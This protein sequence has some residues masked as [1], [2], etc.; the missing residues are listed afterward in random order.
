MANNW[1]LFISKYR[2]I[3]D[4]TIRKVVI[5]VGTKINLLIFIL[6]FSLVN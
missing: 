6:S 1:T 4:N 3:N 2:N 5:P